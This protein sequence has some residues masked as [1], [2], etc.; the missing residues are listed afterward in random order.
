MT[1]IKRKHRYFGLT[2]GQITMLLAAAALNCAIIG[3]GL[4]LVLSSQLPAPVSLTT[5][6]ISATAPGAYATA[7]A[8]RFPPTWTPTP[9]PTVTRTRTPSRTPAPTHTSTPTIE[10]P[11]IVGWEDLS[12][13]RLQ[14]KMRLGTEPESQFVQWKVTHAWVKQPPAIHTI[15]TMDGTGL[16]GGASSTRVEA[17]MLRDKTWGRIGVA[18]W[19]L[20]YYPEA[21]ALRGNWE[22]LEKAFRRLQPAGEDIING[23]RCKH[24]LIDENVTGIVDFGFATMTAHA[25]GDL[26]LAN[27]PDLPVVGIRLRVQLRTND[28]YTPRPSSGLAVPTRAASQPAKSV[29]DLEYD[30]S[31]I[32]TPIRISPPPGFE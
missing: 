4:A 27:Q 12:S 28:W 5:R 30:V 8:S 17:I 2:A 21:Q 3:M 19:Q 18:D 16:P 20:T 10:K 6:L 7:P 15:I 11:I 26:W 1:S 29:F 24:Y 23:I 32:N 22:G 13:Y 25:Q 9:T 31:A 14:F